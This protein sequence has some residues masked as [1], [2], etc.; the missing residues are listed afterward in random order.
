MQLL[1]VCFR[2]MM[3]AICTNRSIMQPLRWHCR[4]GRDGRSGLGGR[5]VGDRVVGDRAAGHPGQTDLLQLPQARQA[6]GLPRVAVD[7]R[8]DSKAEGSTLPLTGCGWRRTEG[9]AGAA[10]AVEG[11]RRTPEATPKH[12]ARHTH[13]Q[14]K[15]QPVTGSGVRSRRGLLAVGLPRF[16]PR[17]RHRSCFVFQSPAFRNT[18]KNTHS[19]KP[20]VRLT[21]GGEIREARHS[22]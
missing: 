2:P 19:I 17:K 12:A 13:A 5:A 10:G 15:A 8:E 1:S 3:M 22:S 4:R 9:A 16:P 7:P 20:Q 18:V 6:H 14:E 11:K 21:L